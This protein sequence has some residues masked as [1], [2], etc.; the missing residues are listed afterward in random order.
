MWG[1]LWLK[2]I[3]SQSGYLTQF[4]LYKGKNEIATVC[5]QLFLLKMANM[6]LTAVVFTLV[7]GQGRFKVL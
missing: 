1:F 5:R 4:F 7:F 2:N 6:Y 3:K